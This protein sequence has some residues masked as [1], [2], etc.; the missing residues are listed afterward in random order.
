MDETVGIGRS[1]GVFCD[2]ICECLE[3]LAAKSNLKFPCC[4]ALAKVHKPK[5][6]G[7]LITV[8]TSWITNPISLYVAKLLQ[9]TLNEMNS[10]A[11]DTADVLVGLK[12]VQSSISPS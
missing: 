9:P 6:A 7:R 5:V 8:G 4:R 3:C 11:K 10:I 1:H 12:N 2:K